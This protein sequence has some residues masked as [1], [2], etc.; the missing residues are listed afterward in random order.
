MSCTVCCL[1]FVAHP[2]SVAP[3]PVPAGVLTERQRRYFERGL[4]VGWQ[5]VGVAAPIKY[6]DSNMFTIDGINFPMVCSWDNESGNL[7]CPIFHTVCGRLLRRAMDAEEDSV[8]S[9]T[10][11]V[12]LEEILGKARGGVYQ[13]RYEQINYG[14]IRCGRFARVDLAPFWLPGDGPGLNTFDYNA[15]KASELAF[16]LTRPDTFPKLHPAVTPARLK[17]FENAPE[18]KDTITS[19]PMAVLEKLISHMTTPAYICFT[20]TCRTLRRHALTAWQKH[21]RSRVLQLDW[22]IPLLAEYRQGKEHGIVMASA[23]ESPLDA[24]WLLYLSHVHRTQSMNV[25]EWIWGMCQQIRRVRDELKPQSEVASVKVKG[26]RKKSKKRK[27][28]EERVGMMMAATKQ[29]PGFRK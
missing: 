19:L 15:L 27:E 10:D 5:L 11:L 14:D 7:T 24:D 20:S 18:T 23:E 12:E 25:R 16:L 17:G 21:A 1:P 4:G 6:L 2:E 13:G 26:V 29:M 22:A 28:L 3:R 9:L 8:K